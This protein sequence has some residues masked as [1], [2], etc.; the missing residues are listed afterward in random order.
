[1]KVYNDDC[2]VGGDGGF[3]NLEAKFLVLTAKYVHFGEDCDLLFVDIDKFL[4]ELRF[5]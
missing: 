4:L 1:M 3:Y 2:G 5:L